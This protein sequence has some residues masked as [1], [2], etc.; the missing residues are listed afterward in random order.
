MEILK[1]VSEILYFGVVI[2][3]NS[4]CRKV[5]KIYVVKGRIIKGVINILE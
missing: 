5:V 3:K 1:V 4:G 2:D